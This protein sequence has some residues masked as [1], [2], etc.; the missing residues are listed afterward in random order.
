MQREACICALDWRRGP[1]E[2]VSSHG[3]GGGWRLEYVVA[4]Y[5]VEKDM[6]RAVEKKREVS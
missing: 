4:V 5:L 3:G 2:G 1:T 6:R